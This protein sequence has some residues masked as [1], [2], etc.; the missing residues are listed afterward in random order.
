MFLGGDSSADEKSVDSQRM[1]EKHG[2]TKD[3]EGEIEQ[4]SVE[5]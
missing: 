4:I 1:G 5:L 3:Q 2:K